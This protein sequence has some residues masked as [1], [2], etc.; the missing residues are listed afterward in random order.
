M[1]N[2]GVMS[3]TTP[4]ELT[5]GEKTTRCRCVSVIKPYEVYG[6]R[7]A[8]KRRRLNLELLR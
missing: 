5:R 2:D 1:C 8:K 7:R 6:R 4:A 3:C